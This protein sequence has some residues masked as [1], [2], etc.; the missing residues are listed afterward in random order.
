MNQNP[1]YFK[2]PDL[3]WLRNVEKGKKKGRNGKNKGRI[4]EEK[5]KNK[6]RK[7]EEKGRKGEEKGKNVI[8]G[9]SLQVPAASLPPCPWHDQ[10]YRH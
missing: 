1:E 9:G 8:L 10:A 5:G 3:Q 6:G 7:R 2:T 4:R